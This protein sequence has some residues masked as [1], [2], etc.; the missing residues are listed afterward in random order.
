MLLTLFRSVQAAKPFN[1][2]VVIPIATV[3]VVDACDFEFSGT[4]V[5]T[6]A[7]LTDGSIVLLLLLPA[8]TTIT[9]LKPVDGMMSLEPITKPTA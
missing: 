7:T 9:Q 8:G 1:T 4:Y 5:A 3:T 6:S 2:S